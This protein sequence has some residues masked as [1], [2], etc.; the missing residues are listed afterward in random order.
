MYTNNPQFDLFQNKYVQLF[1]LVGDW[2]EK[3]LKQTDRR[4]RLMIMGNQR[5]SIG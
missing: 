2:I 1:A 5:D 3:I 4:I